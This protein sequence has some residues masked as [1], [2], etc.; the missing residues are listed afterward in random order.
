MNS[1]CGPI[2]IP[3]HRP[4]LSIWAD[5][6][7]SHLHRRRTAGSSLAKAEVSRRDLDILEDLGVH[8]LRDIGAPE[9]VQARVA[10]RREAEHARL[11]QSLGRGGSDVDWRHW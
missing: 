4:W 2:A 9:W 8:T 11:L 7:W 5:Q 1:V 3:L 6:V 10:A